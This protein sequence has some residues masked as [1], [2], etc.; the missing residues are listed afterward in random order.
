MHC[1]IFKNAGTSL[2]ESFRKAF[3]HN[4]IELEP[5]DPDDYLSEDLIAVALK[6]NPDLVFI[7][8]HRLKLPLPTNIGNRKIIPI[9]FF[10]D[11]IDRLGSVYRFEKKETRPTVYSAL[12]KASSM[13]AFFETIMDVGFDVI[14]SNVHADFCSISSS[15]ELEKVKKYL[16]KNALVGLV[17]DYH[18]SLALIEK[19][20][21]QYFPDKSLIPFQENVTRG[22]QALISN[23]RSTID[24]LGQSLAEIIIKKNYYDYKLYQFVCEYLNDC[25]HDDELAIYY[26][27]YCQFNNIQSKQ[28]DV[29]VK[30]AP[31]LECVKNHKPLSRKQQYFYAPHWIRLKSADQFD[32]NGSRVEAVKIELSANRIAL[33]IEPGQALVVDFRV[34]WSIS[35][36]HPLIGITIKNHRGVPVCSVNNLSVGLVSASVTEGALL[37]YRFKINIPDVESG[38]YKV[39]V[40]MGAGLGQQFKVISIAEAVIAFGIKSSVCAGD[41]FSP[42]EVC[43]SKI[44]RYS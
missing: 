19:K 39:D 3:Q 12:A 6:K 9:I 11:P 17:E 14:V 42:V 41:S 36:N 26:S 35:I 21:K 37:N 28:V 22:K 16:S 15:S 10:R 31:S 18:F 29:R 27:N 1:H 20:V 40:Q 44:E 5:E 33:C 24:E 8:S 34:R 25:W 43:E 23:C 2:I 32:N 38:L 30:C 13:P 4:A 7:S